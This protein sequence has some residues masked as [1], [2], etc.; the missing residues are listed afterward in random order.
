MDFVS[1]VDYVSLLL[2]SDFQW[3]KV[4]TEFSDYVTFTNHVGTYTVP[5]NSPTCNGY[6]IYL[7]CDPELKLFHRLCRTI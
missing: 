2:R 1:F 5:P 6:G 3:K 7:L 4:C